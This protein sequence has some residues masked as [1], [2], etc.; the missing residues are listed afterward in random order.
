[1]QGEHACALCVGA[2]WK[3][4]AGSTD[5]ILDGGLHGDEDAGA[6]NPSRIDAAAN[7]TPRLLTGSKL[8][9]LL[10]GAKHSA[11]KLNVWGR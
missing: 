4:G 2:K 1:M 3:A 9:E 10:D 8:L 6:D 5:L 11:Y 7:L